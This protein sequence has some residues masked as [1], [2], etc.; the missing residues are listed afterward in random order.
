MTPVEQVMS[1]LDDLVRA[2]KLR[3]LGARTS[4][5]GS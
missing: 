5:A 3:Y 4:P 2:G 1:T